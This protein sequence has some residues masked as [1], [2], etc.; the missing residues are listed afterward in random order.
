[1]NLLQAKDLTRLT[2]NNILSNLTNV[3]IRPEPFRLLNTE[4]NGIET[5]VIEM[6]YRLD[7]N[8]FTQWLMK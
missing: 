7:N 3:R 1:M 5:F 6:K 8:V 4:A 2:T